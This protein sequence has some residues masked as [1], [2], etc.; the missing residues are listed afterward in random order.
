MTND[1]KYGRLYPERAVALAEDVLQSVVRAG[2]TTIFAGRAEQAL[3]NLRSLGF[4]PDEPLFLLRG[5][6]ILAPEIVRAYADE[7]KRE[8]AFG[9]PGK[10]DATIRRLHDVADR[11]GYWQPR[12]LPD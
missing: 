12:K 9:R 11:M 4:P 10:N 8:G 7:V 6:D 1:S 2:K 3:V 5:Q